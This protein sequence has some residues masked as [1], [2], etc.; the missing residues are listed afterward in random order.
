MR[1]LWRQTKRLICPWLLCCDRTRACSFHRWRSKHR[2]F[3]RNARCS[4]D[5]RQ[6]SW[7]E[8]ERGSWLLVCSARR[9]APPIG[10]G[11]CRTQFSRPHGRSFYVHLVV[12]LATT[13]FLSTPT[14]CP[15]VRDASV[16]RRRQYTTR[17]L[18]RFAHD[19][20]RRTVR[21]HSSLSEPRLSEC[22][23]L[24]VGKTHR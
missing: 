9:I 6:A 17:G 18:F 23:V 20:F 3:Q 11:R 5:H 22:P 21:I 4:C 1:S 2:R 16:R 15:P 7:T 13:G 24:H 10:G 12:S 19:Y 8:C 14:E